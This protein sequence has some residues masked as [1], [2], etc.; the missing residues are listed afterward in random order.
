MTHFILSR[1][2]SKGF[3][4]QQIPHV[5]EFFVTH[6]MLQ[7]PRHR[8]SQPGVSQLSQHRK[9]DIHPQRLHGRLPCAARIPHAQVAANRAETRASPCSPATPWLVLHHH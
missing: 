9:G 6:F 7:E 5:G 4:P 2:L 8:G 1:L 3:L